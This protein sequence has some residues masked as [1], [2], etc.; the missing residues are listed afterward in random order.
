M[1]SVREARK[2]EWNQVAELTILAN[3]EYAESMN[4]EFWQNY[5]LSLTEAIS[6]DESLLRMVATENEQIAGSVVYYPPYEKQLAGKLVKN[7][8][9]EMRFLSVDPEHRNKGIANLLIDVCEREAAKTG[10]TALTLHTTRLMKIARAMYERR[11]YTRYEQIDFEPVA[12]FTVFGFIKEIAKGQ[13][14]E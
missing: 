5:K 8:F 2:S 3:S 9:P 13:A 4:P 14:D 1:I 11:G 6:K 10:F 7:P 12:G